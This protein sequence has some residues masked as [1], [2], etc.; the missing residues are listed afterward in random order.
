MNEGDIDLTSV[1]RCVAIRA[2]C[3]RYKIGTG[4]DGW[5]RLRHGPFMDVS[6]TCTSSQIRISLHSQHIVR[7]HETHAFRTWMCSG[8]TLSEDLHGDGHGIH[9]DVRFRWTW[10]HSCWSCQ[11]GRR[12]FGIAHND[13]HGS[14]IVDLLLLLGESLVTCCKVSWR[15]KL[16]LQSLRSCQGPCGVE[17]CVLLSTLR[18]ATALGRNIH[19]QSLTGARHVAVG[20]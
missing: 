14:S 11:Y 3:A 16:R 1:V 5:T 6:Y 9:S 20:C 2:H 13:A 15:V 10:K 18:K 17:R 7:T 19:W 8:P 12:W 4:F